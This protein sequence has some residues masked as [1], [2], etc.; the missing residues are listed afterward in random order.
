MRPVTILRDPNSLTPL[1]AIRHDCYLF[2]YGG[3]KHRKMP[4]SKT[5][6]ASPYG[7]TNPAQQRADSGQER[8]SK[9]LFTPDTGVKIS[10]LYGGNMRTCLRALSGGQIPVM[11]ELLHTLQ[12][13]FERGPRSV[14][15]TPPPT[16]M[17]SVLTNKP[18]PTHQ[19][20][21]GTSLLYHTLGT[22]TSR[23]W[24]G[25]STGMLTPCTGVWI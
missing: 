24:T 13:S 18:S 12:R 16:F 4:P 22:T 23:L 1:A 14:K 6:W 8:F 11:S 5:D 25:F 2:L 20:R 7:I 9:G 19:K 21:T 10:F 15:E 17:P 3:N